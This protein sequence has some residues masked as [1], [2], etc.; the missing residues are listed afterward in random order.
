MEI[1][2]QFNTLTVKEYFFYIEH[3]KKY[4]DFNTLGLYRSVLENE[5]LSLAE[6][7]EVRNFAHT[8]F[9]RAFEFLQL[10]DPATYVAISILGQDITVADKQQLWEDLKINQQKI[11]SSKGIKHR[12]FGVYSKHSCDYDNC[13]WNGVMVKS[14]SKLAYD[15]MHFKSDRNNYEAKEKSN[16]RKVE[17]KK[18]RQII[19]S[20]LEEI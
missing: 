2:R 8:Y 16:R 10:K 14:G 9:K 17:R 19:K 5:N 11:L 6:K 13:I 15:S 18:V 3:N 12:N 1:G 4:T 20:E 7:I